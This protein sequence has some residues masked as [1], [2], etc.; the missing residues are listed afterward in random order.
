MIWQYLSQF[1]DSIVA[2]GEYPIAYFQNIGIAV[3]GALGSFFDV[4]FH[5]LNDIFLFLSW[6]G[7]NL[8]NIFLSLL[9]P[10]TY[11]F[12]I[13]R[14]FFTTAFSTPT[15]P[16]PTATFTFSQQVL[17]VFQAI[18]NWQIFSSILGA[19]IIFVVGLS[20]LKL[21]LRS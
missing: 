3:A 13:L 2:V 5:N 11:F 18:P 17:D 9:S 6:S 8:K 10:I 4:I 12:D 21:L 19:V 7:S 20:G 1:W 15:A 16:D 14:F